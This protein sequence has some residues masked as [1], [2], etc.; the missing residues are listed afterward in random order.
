MKFKEFQQLT[1]RTLP[2]LH[3]IYQTE[4][5]SVGN[6]TFYIPG[7]NST[8]NDLPTKDAKAIPLPQILNLIHM[9]LG[10]V[11]EINELMDA[12]NKKDSINIAEELADQLW[13]VAND[14]TINLKTEL[15]DKGT[16]DHYANTE[17]NKGLQATDG[18]FNS[19]DGWLIANM[20]N[21]SKL[22]NLN[23]RYMAYGKLPNTFDYTKAMT[24]FIA[25]INNLAIDYN[26]DLELAMNNVIEKLKVR[27]QDKF[28]AVAAV[29]RD[30][31]AERVELE[32]S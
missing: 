8:I 13:Y 7:K 12:I 3:D 15:I 23:K 25:S 24:Y 10:I 2:Q 9:N 28:D 22:V 11:S 1:K 14:L 20:Y 26:I 18:G 6:L 21:A 27:F 29:N 30:L 5:R 4:G 31:A 19:K 16:Y 32:K 17:F